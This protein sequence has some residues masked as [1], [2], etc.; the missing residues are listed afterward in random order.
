MAKVCIGN[1]KGPKGDTGEK[2][3]T[4]A[5]GAT[6][7]RGSRWS[8]GTKITGTSTTA[9]IFSGSGITDALVNDVYLNTSTGN[10]YRCTV[11]GA[12][13]AAKWVYVGNIKGA[14]GNDGTTPTVADDMTVAFTQATTRANIATGEKTST[15]MGKIKKWFADLTAAAFAQVITSNADLMATTVAGYLPDALAVK[16]QFDTVATKG[17][18][19]WFTGICLSN[20]DSNTMPYIYAENKDGNIYFRFTNSSGNIDYSNLRWL[21]NNINNFATFKGQAFPNALSLYDFDANGYEHPTAYN[22]LIYHN[23]DTN[24]AGIGGNA[25]GDIVFRVGTATSKIFRMTT[26]GQLY[27]AAFTQQSS[28]R[29]KQNIVGLTDDDALK[30]LRL[31]PVKYDYINTQNGVGCYGLI[32]EE[33]NEVMTYP[34][35]YDADGNPDGLDYSKFV[36]YL[37]KL[38]QLHQTRISGLEQENRKLKERLDKIEGRL[39]G[40]GI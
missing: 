12:A 18:K 1:F 39:N 11:G 29:Y 30:L 27:A 40:A 21:V 28:R 5:K 17:K 22:L 24:F 13:A 26:T 9:T 19:A 6:G 37:I 16:Q 35:A 23:S 36:P 2:G 15:L 34:V 32:A 14:K 10:V 31:R 33:V 4:G 7:Q 38:A 25:S 3:D 20:E 8:E